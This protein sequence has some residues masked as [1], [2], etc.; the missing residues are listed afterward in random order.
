FLSPYAH[1]VLLRVYKNQK[2]TLASWVFV[3]I[4][5]FL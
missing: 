2:N 4:F 3:S 1:F 5:I